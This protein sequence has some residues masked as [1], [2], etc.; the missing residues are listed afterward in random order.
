MAPKGS[1]GLNVTELKAPENSHIY[2]FISAGGHMC[3]SA[4]EIFRYLKAF[5]DRKR[6][7][8]VD[9]PIALHLKPMQYIKRQNKILAEE[10]QENLLNWLPKHRSNWTYFPLSTLSKD[11]FSFDGTHKMFHFNSVFWNIIFQFFED[12]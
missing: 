3:Y 5:P 8:Y 9:P 12:L 11:T 4:N 7:I 2:Y 1:E 6:V 10:F